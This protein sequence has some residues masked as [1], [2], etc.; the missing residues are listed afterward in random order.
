DGAFTFTRSGTTS[1][2]PFEG[3]SEQEKVRH[4]GE[5]I[6]PNLF[7]SL[8][9]EHVAAFLLTPEAPDRTR[10]VCEFLFDTAAAAE[11]GFDASDP[12]PSCHLTNRPSSPTS[13]SAHPTL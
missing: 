4:K 13:A 10:I 5:L 9:P 7:L 3:L 2:A 6:Y 1:R 8:S 11:P 12:V